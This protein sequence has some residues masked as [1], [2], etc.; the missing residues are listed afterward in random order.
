M[1]RGLVLSLFPGIDLLGRAFEAQGWCVVWGPDVI[2]GRDIRGWHVPAGRFDGV[3][4]G[5]PCQSFSRLANIVRANGFEPR[6][7][8]LH[9]EFCR[10]IAEAAPRWWLCENVPAAPDP[11]VAG[12]HREQFFCSPRWLGDTQSRKRKF[13]F[14]AQLPCSPPPHRIEAANGRA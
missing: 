12:Y 11:V 3:I 7:G 9:P 14:G 6:F 2:Y 13:T 10:I 5:P 4:G 8:D 1:T